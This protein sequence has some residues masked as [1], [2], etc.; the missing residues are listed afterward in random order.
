MNNLKIVVDYQSI[1]T[2][3]IAVLRQHFPFIYRGVIP[4]NCSHVSRTPAHFIDALS[5]VILHF[6]D[7]GWLLNIG[8]YHQYITVVGR[9]RQEYFMFNFEFLPHLILF[10]IKWNKLI[11]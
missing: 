3:Y 5:T 7:N 6:A 4:D 8:Y 1:V 10:L 11:F 2:L 9:D